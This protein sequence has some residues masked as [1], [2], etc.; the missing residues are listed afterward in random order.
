M[1]KLAL[2]F[3]AA[4]TILPAALT[5]AEED[6]APEQW[7][8]SLELAVGAT[9]VYQGSCGAASDDSLA[10]GS[11]DIEITAPASD[12]GLLYLHMASGSGAGLDDSL[13][14]LSGLNGDADD[15]SNLR[16]TEAWFEQGLGGIAMLRVGRLDMTV[17]FDGNAVANSET[18]QFLSGGFVNNLAAEFPDDNGFG[19]VLRVS[20]SELV[21]LS[22]GVADAR[23]ED[24][25]DLFAIAELALKPVFGELEGNYR[26]YVWYNGKDHENLADGSTDDDNH[27][28]GLS[29][30]QEVGGGVTLF[31]R[32]GW[33]RGEV[34]QV[35]TAWSA[36]LA[37]DGATFGREG[38]TLGLA[39]GMA[40]VGSEWE[41]IDAASGIESGDEGHLEIY[42]N[43]AVGEHILISPDIQWVSNAAGDSASDELF[44]FGLRAQVSF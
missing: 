5:F 13:A 33:Q 12:G 43:C 4:A 41:A 3:V 21:D 15:D 30:D 40:L 22:F 2:A 26:A 44:I 16:L 27:G 32:L 23:G 29:C 18:D 7:Y 9:G 10:T 24:C 42:Y 34:A 11:I 35:G 25:E 19:A 1:K 14:T 17:D 6:S 31:A 36:G 37:L 38:D 28:I 20:P 8:D 39:Y